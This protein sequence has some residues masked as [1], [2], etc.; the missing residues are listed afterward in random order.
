MADFSA[1]HPEVELNLIV[2]DRYCDLDAET[3]DVAIRYGDVAMPEGEVTRLFREFLY[4]VFSADYRKRSALEMAEDL[5]REQLLHLSG[6]YRP[7]AR[8]PHWFD[9][10]GLTPPLE[11]AGVVMN[12]CITMLQAAIEGQGVALAGSPLIDRYLEEGRLLTPRR[13]TPLPRDHY[14]PIDRTEGRHDGK[15]FCAW[16]LRQAADSE[17]SG[18]RS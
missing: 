15:V 12:T 11:S 13:I 9:R 16:F 6:S 2:S 14:Y 5:L 8:W 3:V 7:Q 17:E 4:P 18:R 1:R 10:M